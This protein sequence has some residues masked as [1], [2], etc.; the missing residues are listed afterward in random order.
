GGSWLPGISFNGADPGAKFNNFSP[1]LGFT[2]DLQG[3]GKTLVRANYALYYGQV[4]TGAIASTINP[5]GTTTLRYPWADLNRN[6]VADPGEIQLSASP[7]SASTNWSAANPAN[8]ISANS[9]DP[10]LKNDR[11]DELI[12]GLDRALAA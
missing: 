8:N 10:N 11:T 1:R 7:L 3:N 12:V 2:Y 9:V 6:G 5:V 4:G